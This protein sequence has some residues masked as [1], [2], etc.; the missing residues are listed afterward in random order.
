MKAAAGLLATPARMKT[1][2]KWESARCPLCGHGWANTKH[3][4]NGCEMIKSRLYSWRHQKVM[5]VIV[6]AVQPHWVVVSKEQDVSSIWPQSAGVAELAH[7]RPDLILLD[8]ATEGV[9]R[10]VIL[11]VAVAFDESDN[12]QRAAQEKIRRYGPLARALCK[13]AGTEVEAVID[14][15]PIVIGSLGSVP[16]SLVA[17]LAGLSVRGQQAKKAAADASLAAILASQ[18]IWRMYSGVA[19]GYKQL[20]Q[21]RTADE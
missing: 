11:D 10:M 5:D 13:A 2:N 15:V 17:T 18:W 20:H 7:S 8:G 3:V 4:L 21:M 14:V 1:I 16:S 9:L 12:M 19:F 6:G